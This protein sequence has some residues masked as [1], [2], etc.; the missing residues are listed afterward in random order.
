MNRYLVRYFHFKLRTKTWWTHH[1]YELINIQYEFLF[2]H[3]EK[4]KHFYN[5]TPVKDNII[6]SMF[7]TYIQILLHALQFKFFIVLNSFFF[8]KNLVVEFFYWILYKELLK[9]EFIKRLSLLFSITLLT[10]TTNLFF[11][12]KQKK[13]SRKYQTLQEVLYFFAP[14]MTGIIQFGHRINSNLYMY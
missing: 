11:C 1:T 13:G 10:T 6:M 14:R 12:N 7:H 9:W 4:L 3:N 8:D 5:G 2:L